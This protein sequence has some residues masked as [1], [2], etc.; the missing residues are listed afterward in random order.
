MPE[1]RA[2]E[3][4]YWKEH[5]DLL[6]SP[7]TITKD[8][9]RIFLLIASHFI[10]V[11]EH[12]VAGQKME[13]DGLTW[14]MRDVMTIIARR[15]SDLKWSSCYVGNWPVYM[16]G[17]CAETKEDV[18]LVR[19]DLQRRWQRTHFSMITRYMEHLQCTWTAKGLDTSC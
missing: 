3:A 2:R 8:L 10:N 9:T 18:A 12:S 1:L 19:S 6:E 16:A 14:Q 5:Q 11:L 15:Q 13:F 17:I 4:H 7:T